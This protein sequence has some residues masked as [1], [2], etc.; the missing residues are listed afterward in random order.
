MAAPEQLFV[1]LFAL[2]S[3]VPLAVLAG[4]LLLTRPTGAPPPGIRRFPLAPMDGL[5]LGL[6]VGVG[7]LVAPIPGLALL[8]AGVWLTMRPTCFELSREGLEIVW[9][10][11]RER[12]PLAAFTGVERLSRA[13]L[14]ARYGRGFRYGAGGFGGGF[15][16]LITPKQ[17]FRMYISRLDEHVL[18]HVRTGLPLL[19]SPNDAPAFVQCLEELAGLPP[20]RP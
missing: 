9:P 1:I 13:E 8:L 12:F 16:Q 3:L 5:N 20:Q 11:R 2:G 10:L 6:T 18:L 15:G 4:A 17:R 19:I 14:G 7:L